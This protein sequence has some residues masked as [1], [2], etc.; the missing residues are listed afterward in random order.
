MLYVTANKLTTP[1]NAILLQHTAP[2]WV[3][4]AGGILLGERLRKRQRFAAVLAAAGIA[5]FLS[6]GLRFGSLA[7][8]AVAL[9]CGGAFALSMIALRSLKG[10]SPTLALFWS[11][12]IPAVC[13]L[14][15]VILFPP[16]ITP[17]SLGA[18]A[19]LGVAQ[20]GA[21]SL[22]YGYAIKRITAMSA[23]LLA[24]TEPILNPVWVFLFTGEAPA[25]YAAAG[26]AL[27]IAAVVI[28]ALPGRRAAK[29][30]SRL[31]P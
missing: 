21:A 12:I 7:G 28:D 27:I 3:A 20:I 18:A 22:L 11:H 31:Q 4:L 2:V 15:F 19:F 25:P 6:G 1:A 23:A 26:G 24:Q 17:Q 10:G 5:V 16:D 13:A 9:C 14:P 30:D 29:S 8:D